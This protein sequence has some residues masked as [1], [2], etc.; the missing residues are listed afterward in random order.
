MKKHISQLIVQVERTLIAP[1][2]GT[3]KIPCKDIHKYE[4][5][6]LVEAE[7]YNTPSR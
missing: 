7:E 6:I 1:K 5:K 3:F 4:N 2:R